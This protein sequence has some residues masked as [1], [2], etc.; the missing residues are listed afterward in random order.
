MQYKC[1]QFK[2]VEG[3]R[4]R[5]GSSVLDLGT[6]RADRNCT[7]GHLLRSVGDLLW[8]GSIGIL[9]RSI[10]DL[11]NRGSVLDLGT[12]RADRNCTGGHLLRS[13]GDLLNRGRGVGDLLNRGSVLGANG[14]GH[15]RGRSSGVG[16]LL[17]RG[18]VLGL[19]GN[20]DDGLRSGGDDGLRSGGDDGLRSGGDDGDAPCGGSVGGINSHLSIV[21]GLDTNKQREYNTVHTD[22]RQISNI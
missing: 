2:C 16:D 5:H 18:S 14:A 21:L 12:S 9:L 20:S 22:F 7:G 4:Y 17:D 6:S 10:G 15:D 13:V 8:G 3:G 11:L 1:M 19:G